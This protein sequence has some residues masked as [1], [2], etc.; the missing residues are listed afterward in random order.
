MRST[1][2]S[3]LVECYWPDVTDEKLAAATH[4]IVDATATAR[5]GGAEVHYLGAFVMP[6]DE[7][8]F[9][10]F[11][12]SE[13]AVRAISVDAKLPFERVLALRWLGPRAADMQSR[14]PG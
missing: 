4:R 10:L 13:A 8:V 2:A 14:S 3:H 12:G 5:S 1:R 6:A 9:C 11:N 7:T